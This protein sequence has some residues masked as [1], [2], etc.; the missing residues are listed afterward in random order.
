MKKKIISLILVLAL[1][2]S[3]LMLSASADYGSEKTVLSLDAVWVEDGETPQIVPASSFNSI[4]WILQ[5][6]RMAHLISSLKIIMC[7]C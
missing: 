5:V 3:I 1:S 7:M 4:L 6:R 2:L